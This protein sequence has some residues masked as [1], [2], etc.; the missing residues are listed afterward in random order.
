MSLLEKI[1]N[2]IRN[3]LSQTL[4]SN[5]YFILLAALIPGVFG[6]VFW[7]VVAR[8]LPVDQ[9]GI[10]SALI[11]VTAFLTLVSGMDLGTTLIRY[12]PA[13]PDPI[14]LIN[15]SIWLRII[16]ATITS[17]VFLAG[18][19]LWSPAQSFLGRSVLLVITFVLANMIQ[20]L[21]E[22][23]VH[24]FVAY[25]KSQL[26]LF[27]NIYVT[28][29]R[30][31]VV[32]AGALLIPSFG[33]IGLY[34]AVTASIALVL[35]YTIWNMIPS[36]VPNYRFRLQFDQSRIRPLLRFSTGNF[37]AEL[38]LQ[39]PLLLIPVIVVNRLSNAESGI[40]YVVM[41]LSSIVAM[42]PMGLARSLLSEGAH[43]QRL[44]RL[45]LLRVLVL[46]FGLELI[47]I[48]GLVLSGGIL[49][50]LTFG[51]IYADHGVSFLR[52]STIAVIPMTIVFAAYSLERIKGRVSRLMLIGTVVCVLSLGLML[53]LIPTY[54][55][56]GVGVGFLVGQLAGAVFSLSSIASVIRVASRG[57]Q[58]PT[59][60]SSNHKTFALILDEQL[61]SLGSNIRI[62]DV[63]CGSG[64]L[65]RI[66]RQATEDSAEIIGV[67]VD[68]N[69]LAVAHIE[70]NDPNCWYIHYD[71]YHLPLAPNSIDLAIGQ[72]VIEHVPDDTQFMEALA[73][74]LKPGGICLLTT[75]NATRQP[76]TST[77][78]PDHVRHYTPAALRELAVSSGFEV[79]DSYYRYHLLSGI[80][81]RLLL[82]VGRRVLPTYE[83]QPHMTVLENPSEH[84]LLRFY[85]HWIDPFITVIEQTEF[86]LM[87]RVPAEGQ[88]C[89]MRKPVKPDTSKD[90]NVE[91]A[92]E[93]A[94]P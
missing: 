77:S 2:Y 43:N 44:L 91:L 80:M 18:L 41:M 48:V 9:V 51:Q 15:T 38:L 17:L 42:V 34:V 92:K 58:Q 20:S 90:T 59:E 5:A 69:A 61:V 65:V 46:S 87:R 68:F 75:P 54:G 37:V 31:P 23:V 50:T 93:T 39:M 62:L 66:I 11:S 6:Y 1:I 74:V 72:E 4:Y 64:S 12:L 10:A 36:V 84:P 26:A 33:A 8:L 83:V 32:I 57:V 21:N 3:H 24:V 76:L 67:D 79:V 27:K 82:M 40:A 52:F 60:Y 25:R 47:L 16:M 30:F 55:L 85:D 7:G 53:V 45:N 28:I 19:S 88:V 81:D 89:V 56:T 71:G 49:L 94:T 14:A 73:Y 70:H 86:K 13:D 78:H 22:L 63:G 29:A 35:V